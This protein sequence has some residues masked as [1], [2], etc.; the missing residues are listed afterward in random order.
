M[1]PNEYADTLC[2]SGP[3]CALSSVLV[4]Q[5]AKSDWINYPWDPI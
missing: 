1:V 3:R 2:I 5:E 4:Q